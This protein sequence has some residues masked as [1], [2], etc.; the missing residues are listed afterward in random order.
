MT[1]DKVPLIIIKYIRS[2]EFYQLC[3]TIDN[4]FASG[5]SIIMKSSFRD[6]TRPTLVLLWISG[7]LPISVNKDGSY[8]FSWI[9]I[10]TAY[11]AFAY[12]GLNIVILE[13]GKPRVTK[14]SEGFEDGLANMFIL[15]LMWPHFVLPPLGVIFTSDFVVYLNQWKDIEK[16]FY[17]LTGKKLEFSNLKI[18]GIAMPVFC[19]LELLFLLIEPFLLEDFTFVDSA[20]LSLC[21]LAYNSITSMWYVQAAVIASTFDQLRDQLIMDLQRNKGVET[22]RKYRILYINACSLVPNYTKSMI[23]ITILQMM[24]VYSNLLLA[25][26]AIAV[27]LGLT[28][29]IFAHL[30]PLMYCVL[31]CKFICDAGELINRAAGVL[32][33]ERIAALE[34]H[35]SGAISK[36]VLKLMNAVQVISPN[37]DIAGYLDLNRKMYTSI[38]N[39]TMTHIIILFQLRG[40]FH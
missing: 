30:Y 16:Y 28:Y 5:P 17:Y 32:F 33:G 10:D 13:A 39:T 31:V 22:I 29:E 15:G 27:T 19:I 8:R 34:T 4:L 1:P 36:E 12:V 23:P 14:M 6:I 26:Y 9:S 2:H 20:S 35:S 40:Q 25:A 38:V 7:V 11:A 21:L 3:S 24:C 37:V 18:L